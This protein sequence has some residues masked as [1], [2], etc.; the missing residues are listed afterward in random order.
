MEENEK[1]Q[2]NTNTELWE[3]YNARYEKPLY[4]SAVTKNSLLQ[5]HNSHHEPQQTLWRTLQQSFNNI[6]D[7][8]NA[9]GAS[10]H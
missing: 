2:A 9:Q 6:G 10:E 1:I 3:K 7:L 5:L 8:H 4:Q